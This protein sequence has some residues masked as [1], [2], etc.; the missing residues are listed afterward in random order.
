MSKRENKDA[1]I[2]ENK[3]SPTV[4]PLRYYAQSPTFNLTAFMNGPS[5]SLKFLA[6]SPEFWGTLSHSWDLT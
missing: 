4:W 1:D 5:I 3:T 2:N 6:G